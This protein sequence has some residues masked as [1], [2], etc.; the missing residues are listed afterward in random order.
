[1]EER[2]VIIVGGGIGGLTAAY[3]ALYN[4]L[5]TTIIEK[6][7]SLGGAGLRHNC[8]PTKVLL[9]SAKIAH[10]IKN[11]NCF[12]IDSY[13]LTTDLEKINDHVDKVITKL[14]TKENYK[15]IEE[16]GGE[17]IFATPRFLDLNTIMV[18][19]KRLKAKHFIL[20]TGSRTAIPNIPG[21][22]ALGYLSNETIFQ[23]N[24][25]TRKK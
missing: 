8:I 20:A 22:N 18:G 23:K 3:G 10:T 4:N 6:Q 11:S 7:S 24:I 5:S 17:V 16:M 2:D 13:L 25:F 19:N 12:G 1:M 14:Q 15:W 21:L 9:H